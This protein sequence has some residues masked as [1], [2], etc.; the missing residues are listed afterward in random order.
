MQNIPWVTL[1]TDLCKWHLH[2]L[3]DN[4]VLPHFTWEGFMQID[5]QNAVE[6]DRLR[7]T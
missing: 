3:L 4:H 1:G 5:T 2:N 6:G 7:E